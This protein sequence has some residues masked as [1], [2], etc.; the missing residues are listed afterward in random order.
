PYLPVAAHDVFVTRELL[1]TD[2]PAGV[3]PVRGDTDLGAH[4]ELRTVREL[5]GGVVEHDRTVDAPEK[6]LRRGRVLR[7]DRFGVRG[8]VAGDVIDRSIDSVDHARGDD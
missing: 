4:A 1:D 6:A 7:D 2:R 3:E 8:A 5:H